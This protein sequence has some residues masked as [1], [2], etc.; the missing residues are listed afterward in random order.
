MPRREVSAT[1]RRM[2]R[3]RGAG[4]SKFRRPFL[5]ESPDT[6]LDLGRA[7][8]LDR[9]P[10]RSR[11]VQPS[12]G[13][14]VDRALHAAHRDRRVAGQDRR[15][16]VDLLIERFKR[17]HCREVADAQHLRRIEPLCGEKQLFALLTPSRDT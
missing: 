9:A 10:V 16:A 7:H 1:R 4:G 8:A 15:K 3:L 12:A 5:R 17:H 14:L 2:A 6:F 13:E 11:L